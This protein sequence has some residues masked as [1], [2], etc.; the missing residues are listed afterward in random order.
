MESTWISFTRRASKGNTFNT[1]YCRVNLLTELLPL[2][3]YVDGRRLAINADNARPHTAR[4]GRAFC[5]ENR[6]LLGG[7][8]PCSPDLALSA[9]FLFGHIKHCLQGIAFPSREELIA[10]V[11]EIVAAIPRATMEEVF[12][13]WM[14]RLEWVSQDDG[15]YYPEVK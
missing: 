2:G 14:E 11:H 6:L 1:E 8:P 7:H 9:F 4:K 15:D 10:T 5:E 12:R 3:P 13:H